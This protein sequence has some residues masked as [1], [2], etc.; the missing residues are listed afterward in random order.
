MPTISPYTESLVIPQYKTTDYDNSLE[1]ALLAKKQQQY[2][3]F[4]SRLHNLQNTSLNI[5][6]LNF[7][8]QEKLDG[9]NKEINN[10]LSQD[11][12]DLT[13]PK[14]QSRLASV[15]SKISYDTDLKER[16]KLSSHYQQQLSMIES[17]RNSKDPT[18]SGYNAINETVFRKWDGGLEDF[19]MADNINGWSNKQQSYTPFK[20]IDQKLV[21]LTKLL[22]EESV[23]EQKPVKQT[24][25]GPDGKIQEVPSGYDV[26]TSNKGV[27]S[28]RIR[29][30]L[31]S[32]LDADERAQLEVLSKYRVL[33]N[34]SPEGKA[35]LYNTYNKWLSA[36]NNN[37]KSEI[38]QIKALREQYKTTIENL[39]LPPNELA[40]KKAVYQ[41]QI[42]KLTEKENQLTQKAAQQETNKMSLESWIKMSN[43]EILPF[44]N[45]LTTEHFVNGVA[46]AL[47]WKEE[48]SKVGVDQAFFMGERIN[49][50]RE[51]LLLDKQLGEAGL[52]IR[53]AELNLKEKELNHKIGKESESPLSGPE[54]IFK[55]ASELHSSWQKTVELSNEYLNKVT[56]II[57]SKS[58]NNYDLDGKKLLDNRWLEQHS[59]NDEVKLWNQY[60]GMYGKN[61]AFIDVKSGK[62]NFA[63]FEAFKNAVRNGD[64]KNNSYLNS[65]RAEML[66]NEQASEYLLGIQKKAATAVLNSSGASEVKIGNGPALKDYSYGHKDSEGNLLFG[67]KDGKG[68]YKQMTWDQIKQEYKEGRERGLS[69]SSTPVIKSAA[70]VDLDAYK[71]IGQSQPPLYKGILGNDP[72]FLKLVEKAIQKEEEASTMIQDV[73]NDTLPQ[74]IQNKHY[75]SSDEKT[76]YQYAGKI[77]AATKQGGQGMAFPPEAIQMIAIPQGGGKIGAFQIKPGWEKHTDGMTLIDVAGNEVSDPKPLTWYKADIPA[78]NY[79]NHLNNSIF[80]QKGEISRMINGKKVTIR[81]TKDGNNVYVLIDGKH[82]SDTGIP[83]KDIDMMFAEAELIINQIDQSK[84]LPK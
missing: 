14:V 56:P 64:F 42:D 71:G 77:V 65:I 55:D 62:P 76:I 35:N 27:T 8:G 48:A 73:I 82:I 9:Y 63:G 10:M 43:N 69:K 11:I 59:D 50:I 19:M 31:E 51:R 20:D 4:L 5:S 38:L 1:M 17:M 49:T 46:D 60:V 21:N 37:T 68:G 3:T 22:H 7:K 80:E 28:E 24:V 45:Q 13:D 2:D 75:I 67:V 53:Q 34:N 32:T 16:S 81:D 26:L 36:E 6:M 66:N 54:D 25:K 61:A 47:A 18:K 79:R 41:D 52:A 57:T 72:H 15:F 70:S 83:K 12:G 44:I 58:G 74:W 29:G 33:Q 78:L 84:A 23:L 39:N 30:L 40:V